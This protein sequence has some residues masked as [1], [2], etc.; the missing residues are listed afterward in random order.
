[1]AKSNNKTNYEILSQKELKDKKIPFTAIPNE[2]IELG[3]K[4]DSS[5]FFCNVLYFNEL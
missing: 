2:L 3:V 1:M 4:Y 5:H